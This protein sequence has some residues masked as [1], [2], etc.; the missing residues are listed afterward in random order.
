MFPVWRERCSKS[1]CDHKV[2]PSPFLDGAERSVQIL[3]LVEPQ[4]QPLRPFRMP[5][6]SVPSSPDQ[7]ANSSQ[8]NDKDNGPR[9]SFHDQSANSPL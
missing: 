2:R 1:F 9:D 7:D 6:T 4:E 8:D 5:L 3:K